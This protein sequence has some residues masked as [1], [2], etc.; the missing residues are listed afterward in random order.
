VPQHRPRI[1]V[2]GLGPAGTDLVGDNVTALLGAASGRAYLRTARHPAATAFADVPA[3][4]D[5]YE[6]AATFDEVYGSIVEALVTAA[7]AAAP[8]PVVYAVP[9]SPLI[10]ERTVELLRADARVEVTALPALSFLDLAWAAL[11]YT[12][13][14]MVTLIL[15]AA[16]GKRAAG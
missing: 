10:A 8:Q 5:A 6:T 2:V 7:V 1:T 11:A 16:S 4:D 15:I 14:A 9:G 13:A 3:F 12:V